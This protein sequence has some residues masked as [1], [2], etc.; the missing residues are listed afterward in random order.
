MPPSKL[1]LKVKGSVNI[2]EAHLKTPSLIYRDANGMLKISISALAASGVLL[3]L[4]LTQ[5]FTIRIGF[6][7]KIY[8]ICILLWFVL[9]LVVAWKIPIFDRKIF[10]RG[11]AFFFYAV[12]ALAITIIFYKQAPYGDL[13]RFTPLMDGLLKSGYALLCVLGFVLV[14]RAT[15]HFPHFMLQLWLWGA[16]FSAIVHLYLAVISALGFPIPLLPGMKVPV[17]Q[18]LIAF[19]ELT[20]FRAGTFLE[21]NY[22]GPFFV[23][24]FLIAFTLRRFWFSL[25]FLAA[26][27]ASFSTTAFIALASCVAYILLKNPQKTMRLYLMVAM[28]ILVLASAPVLKTIVLEKFTDTG[29]E[30]SF[31]ERREAFA[32]A[33]QMF[34]EHPL[35]GVGA[36][37][38]GTQVEGRYEWISMEDRPSIKSDSMNKEIPNSIYAEI[39]CEYGLVGVGLF[40][41]FLISILRLAS[42]CSLSTLKAGIWAI[43]IFWIAAPTFTLMYYWIYFAVV[44][45]MARHAQASSVRQ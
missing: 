21:G 10:F 31:Q 41:L 18:Q 30:S 15:S 7:L 12:I 38:Y 8:E 24:S 19:H 28:I 33:W 5:L 3:T 29:R 44:C 36:S 27:A 23:L 6:P 34:T 14:A 43:F 2:T 26:L 16:V 4:P 11:I 37:Q 22:A 35:L 13:A 9:S 40:I 17:N 45:G 25:L 32:T 39:L 42:Q 20:I 1:H